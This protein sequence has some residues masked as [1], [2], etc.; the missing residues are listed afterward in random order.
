MCFD[1]KILRK[2]ERIWCQTPGKNEKFHL[3]FVVR[4]SEQ[5]MVVEPK[6]FVKPKIG[7]R[8]EVRGRA[9]VLY[10]P[11]NNYWVVVLKTDKKTKRVRIGRFP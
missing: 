5:E 3:L 6:S 4:N 1:S 10:M 7:L 2:F 8:D 11:K 9:R